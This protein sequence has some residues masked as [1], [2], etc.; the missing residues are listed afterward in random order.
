MA[1]VFIAVTVRAVVETDDTW[2]ESESA[3]EMMEND[4]E[5]D[6]GAFLSNA[7]NVQIVGAT[8]VTPAEPEE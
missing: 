1:K 6:P 8:F 4:L 7:K 2:Y 3:V 5:S